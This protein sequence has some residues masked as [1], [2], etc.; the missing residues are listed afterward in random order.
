MLTTEE[1]VEPMDTIDTERLCACPWPCAWPCPDLAVVGG[2]GC[3]SCGKNC[4]TLPLL[5]LE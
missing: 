3:G 1:V 2:G 5:L 4:V